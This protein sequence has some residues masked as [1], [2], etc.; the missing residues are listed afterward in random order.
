M[1]F[2][3]LIRHYRDFIYL[4]IF[5]W[6]IGLFA[7]PTKSIWL[8]LLLPISFILIISGAILWLL[9]S[10][11]N[12]DDPF[13]AGGVLHMTFDQFIPFFFISK[14]F[15]L[16]FFMLITALTTRKIVPVLEEQME[17]DQTVDQLNWNSE[18]DQIYGNNRKYTY[19]EW[20][21]S[22]DG[23]RKANVHTKG[24]YCYGSFHYIISDAG[25]VME[26]TII[27][28]EPVEDPF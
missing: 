4:G 11:K 15:W 23:Y 21:E 20:L 1:S 28:Y 8:A 19:P 27:Q 2:K 26:I 10:H 16:A 12:R 22:E 5:L 18:L 24:D 3:T 25:K 13:T 9:S 7:Y 17:W 14:Y 6:M